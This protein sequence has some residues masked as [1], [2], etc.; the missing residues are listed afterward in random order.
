MEATHLVIISGMSRDKRANPSA[1][2]NAEFNKFRS[3]NQWVWKAKA[4]RGFGY[5]AGTYFFSVCEVTDTLGKRRL[6]RLTYNRNTN[7]SYI[8]EHI[9]D[10][11]DAEYFM[12]KCAADMDDSKV[13]EYE[14]DI[15]TRWR[16]AR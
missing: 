12:M 9:A 5:I 14:L 4:N 13:F 8:S 3:H 16:D 1:S 2:V 15:F 7:Q 10:D 11:A 6:V